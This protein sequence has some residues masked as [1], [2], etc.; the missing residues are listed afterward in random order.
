MKFVDIIR[1]NW[2]IAGSTEPD[3]QIYYLAS[4]AR[5][6]GSIRRLYILK[7]QHR[8]AIGEAPLK[9]GHLKCVSGNKLSKLTEVSYNNRVKDAAKYKVV[10]V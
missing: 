3:T 4:K 6:R 5:I 1:H 8:R 2:Q 7:L 10:Q 9:I